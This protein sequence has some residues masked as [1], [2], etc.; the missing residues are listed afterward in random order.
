VAQSL[1]GNPE[2]NQAGF[3]IGL[4]IT[5]VVDTEADWKNIK[6]LY[7]DLESTSARID[8]ST[9]ETPFYTF[10]AWT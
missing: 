1:W 10:S 4:F 7:S 5:A 9:L 6:V 3:H 8:V 2:F